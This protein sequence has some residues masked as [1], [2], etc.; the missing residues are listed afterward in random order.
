MRE[1]T[2]AGHRIADDTPA[3]V[4]AELGTNHQ[5]SIEVARKLITAA[6]ECGVD[7][8][9]LQKRNNRTLFTQ[10]LFDAPYNS[11]HAFGPTYGQHREALEFGI[12]AY[13]ELRR[14]ADSLGLVFFATAFDIPSVDF[15]AALD[16][17]AFKIASGD[18][19]NTPLIRYAAQRGHP[20]IISTGGGCGQDM[21]RANAALRDCPGA[22]LHCTAAY[23][24][25]P[26]EMNLR[27]IEYMR[28]LLPDRVIGLSNHHS[29]ILMPPLAY[30]LG[31]RIFE[32]HFTINRTMKGSDHA[33]SLEPAGMRKLVRDLRR[34]Y[35]ALG[36]GVK[37]R[38]PSED[39]PL[40]KMAKSLVA[41][42]NLPAGTVL[43]ASDV[44][45]K[46]PC[47][48]LPPWRLPEVLGRRL[49]ASLWED[50]AVSLQAVTEWD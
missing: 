33:F 48:G 11:E 1:L 26:G 7:A 10:A 30:A 17:P 36:D 24:C 41:A 37:R 19:Q 47:G 20:V 49:T 13:E 29:G 38:Y 21:V 43:E 3:F 22:F 35:E 4:V 45:I 6:A 32:Q 18:L 9:K 2:I 44:A 25:E 31:A 8:V 23:P 12:D 39:A 46:S 14:Y 5:G 34:T 16:M 42:R 40:Y 27:V 15:L 28:A 50:E